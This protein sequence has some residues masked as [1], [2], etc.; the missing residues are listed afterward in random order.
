M[1]QVG[2]VFFPNVGMTYKVK[3]RWWWCPKRRRFNVFLSPCYFAVLQ[4]VNVRKQ[5]Y[6]DIHNLFTLQY[7]FLASSCS[8]EKN[9]SRREF[10]SVISVTKSQ[11]FA[12]PNVQRLDEK[13][14]YL[15]DSQELSYNRSVQDPMK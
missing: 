10:A 13:F 8:K 7:L 2:K 11:S 5:R 9:L 4:A 12:I 14:Y 6:E 3:I 15:S 1:S